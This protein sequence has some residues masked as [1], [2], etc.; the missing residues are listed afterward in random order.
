MAYLEATLFGFGFG[1]K[2]Q[3]YQ[4]KGH[5][6]TLGEQ[7]SLKISYLLNTPLNNYI[8][9]CLSANSLGYL[10]ERAVAGGGKIIVVG[11]IS[12]FGVLIAVFD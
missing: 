4:R 3:A 6:H 5:V 1:D 8:K 11:I 7:A 10:S 2:T 12:S 9:L